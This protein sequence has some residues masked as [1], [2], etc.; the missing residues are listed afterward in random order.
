MPETPGGVVH[1]HWEGLAQ[2]NNTCMHS[3]TK[4]YVDLQSTHEVDTV[5]SGRLV[6]SGRGQR[7]N[8][9]L[10]RHDGSQQGKGVIQSLA[11]QDGKAGPA[12]CRPHPDRAICRTAGKQ[13][14]TAH[15]AL[16]KLQQGHD[17]TSGM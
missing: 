9:I 13:G 2:P 17:V 11:S 10:V 8:S 3:F 14:C 12:A 5:I 4:Q 1:E 6:V 16:A 7:S 15:F